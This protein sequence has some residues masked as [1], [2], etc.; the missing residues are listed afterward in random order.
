MFWGI[1]DFKNVYQPR[2]KMA[3]DEKGDLV[4]DSQST[5]TL[6][7]WR[8]HFPEMFNVHWVNNVRQTEI[9]TTEPLVPEPSVF[10]FE[11]AIE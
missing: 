10:E 7:K 3:K 8:N 1:S 11:M 9:H 2:T 6:A 5:R 4:T